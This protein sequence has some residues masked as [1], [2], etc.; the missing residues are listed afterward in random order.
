MKRRTLTSWLVYSLLLVSAACAVSGRFDNGGTEIATLDQLVA[1]A[2]AIGA[3]YPSSGDDAVAGG[4]FTGKVKASLAHLNTVKDQDFDEEG[5]ERLRERLSDLRKNFRKCV[6][7]LE[8]VPEITEEDRARLTQIDGTF[9]ETVETLDEDIRLDW[10]RSLRTRA[11]GYVFGFKVALIPYL[12]TDDE[13]KMKH[14]KRIVTECLA[15][16]TGALKGIVREGAV[17]GAL[18]MEMIKQQARNELG[19]ESDLVLAAVDALLVQFLPTAGPLDEKSEIMLSE[20]LDGLVKMQ[21]A[22]DAELAEG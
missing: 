16:A 20:I 2:D 10:E 7:S 18:N 19:S 1:Q 15:V 17:T 4:D 14:R 8:A 21:H 5:M 11:S 3:V 12:F 9:R 22:Y 6:R 13:A